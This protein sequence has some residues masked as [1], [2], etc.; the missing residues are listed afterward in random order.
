MNDLL[1]HTV[2]PCL[3]A[4]D[5]VKSY[6]NYKA[7]KRICGGKDLKSSQAYPRQFPSK[8][9]LRKFCNLFCDYSSTLCS[10]SS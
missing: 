7:K 10:V 8:R 5:M 6:T 2:E 4:R 3:E 9:Q 1:D